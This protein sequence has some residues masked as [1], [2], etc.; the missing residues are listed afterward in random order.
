MGRGVLN[1]NYIRTKPPD[2]VVF[3]SS[4]RVWK[5]WP[6]FGKNKGSMKLYSVPPQ[7]GR[8]GDMS[9]DGNGPAVSVSSLKP[10]ERDE[11]TLLIL[12]PTYTVGSEENKPRRTKFERETRR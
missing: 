6:F 2:S 3:I 8:D 4:V 10:Q 11:T 5:F 12:T 7:C 9:R 1:Q